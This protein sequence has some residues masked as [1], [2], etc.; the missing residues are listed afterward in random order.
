MSQNEAQKQDEVLIQSN[1]NI[2][3]PKQTKKTNTK[4]VKKA[5][6]KTTTK[7]KQSV[8][9][10]YYYEPSFW[11]KVLNFLTERWYAIL[12]VIGLLFINFV[13]PAIFERENHQEKAIMYAEAIFKAERGSDV[14]EF[15]RLHDEMQ[16]YANGLSFE[17]RIEF[18]ATYDNAYNNRLTEW[19]FRERT[20]R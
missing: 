6:K 20:G 17:E 2:E 7:K 16:N 11:D 3:K 15:R 19:A 1:D 5:P 12:V 14:R 9:Q 10:E 8:K 18:F 4:T 13:M